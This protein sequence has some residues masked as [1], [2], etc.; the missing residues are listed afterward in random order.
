MPTPRHIASASLVVLAATL[1][2]CAGYGQAP[3]T[4]R[5]GT[6]G[7]TG[8]G[9]PAASAP[10]NACNAQPAQSVVGQNSTASVVESAR[11]RSGAQMAR[12][13][14]RGSFLVDGVTRSD[15]AIDGATVDVLPPFAGG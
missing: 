12:V 8:A 11:V 4:P 2:G 14:R 15:G 9:A 1:A 13:L 5:D 10:V 7:A 3:A 6:V